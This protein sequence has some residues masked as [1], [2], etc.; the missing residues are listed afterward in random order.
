MEELHKSS[1]TASDIASQYWCERQMEYNYRYG[2]RI[3]EQIKEGKLLHEELEEET[4]VPII[5]QPKSYPD[6]M[7]KNLY[8]SYMALDALKR[9]KKT[10]EIQI[11]GSIGG[12]K[13]VGKMDQLE[14]KDGK[15]AIF[16]DKTRAN[17][18][19]PSRAQGITHRIQIMIYKKLLDDIVAGRYA[20]ENFTRGYRTATMKLT[21]EFT[22]QLDALNISRDQQSIDSVSKLF[23]QGLR[24]LGSVSNTLSIRYI[25]QFTGKEIDLLKFEY[26]DNEMQDV[27]RYILKYWTGERESMPVP[28]SE[29][30]K[31]NYCVFFGKE[32]K[33]WW[34][35]KELVT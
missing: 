1:I 35:Q 9:N 6:A 14:I 29:K 4:N 27:I 30:W 33:V 22:R 17:H 13:L 15:V 28:E 11:Y 18:N 8:T 3:T 19:I 21:E 25:N 7:Y 31:C 5:L 20:Y 24:S 12:Y 2:R 16:E 34:P 23:F 26:D 10:R 32:C